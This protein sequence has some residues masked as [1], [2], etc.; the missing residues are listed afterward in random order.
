V[1]LHRIAAYQLDDQ[2]LIGP[3]VPSI[4]G[5]AEGGGYSSLV[6]A[7]LQQLVRAGDPKDDASGVGMW[8]KRNPNIVFFSHPSLRL[9]DLLQVAYVVSPVP[10]T[11]L[12]VRAEVMTEGCDGDSGEIA[13]RHAVGGSFVVQEATI[14]RLDLRFR[15]YRPGQTSG[16]LAVRMWQGADRGRLM[17]D[18]QLDTAALEDQQKVTLYFAPEGD[19]PGQTYVWEVTATEAAPPTGVGLCTLTDGQPAISVYGADWAPAYQGEVYIYERLAP[20]PRAYV[21]YAA[22][23]IPDDG[24]AVSRLLDESFALRNVAVVAEPLDLPAKADIRASRAEVVTYEDTRV[25]VRASAVQ[26]G[27]LILGDQFHPGWRAHVDGQAVT[28]RRVNHV[29]RGVVL[30]PGEHQVVFQFA[31]LSLR[32]GGGLSLIGI[33]VLIILVAFERHPRV[34]GWLRR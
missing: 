12:G 15:V 24:Q 29:L 3:N 10:L 6:S 19:A 8:L 26:Q 20:L 25:V 22:E 31:P 23:Y 27:L 9:L 34:A 21:V 5:L 11:D 7:R 28:I 33:V 1:G 32:I 30:P 17:L 2:V 18:T 16:T 4:Y 13:G 14:N